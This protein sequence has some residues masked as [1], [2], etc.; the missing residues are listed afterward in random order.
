MRDWGDAV[1]GVAECCQMQQNRAAALAA[2]QSEVVCI[3][4]N[5]CKGSVSSKNVYKGLMFIGKL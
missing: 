3:C 2:S 4:A 1:S 5:G